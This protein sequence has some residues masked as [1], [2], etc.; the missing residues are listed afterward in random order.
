MRLFRSASKGGLGLAL[1]LGMLAVATQHSE[2]TPIPSLRDHRESRMAPLQILPVQFLPDA[3]RTASFAPSQ[4]LMAAVLEDAVHVYCKLRVLHGRAGRKMRR[5][6]EAWFSSR[7]AEW[8]FSFR[9]ICDILDLDAEK[10]LA[11][12][13]LWAEPRQ[14]S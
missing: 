2:P 14:L 11:R 5:E 12:L 9:N 7:D 4:Q 6:L 3:R 10:I 1:Q 13:G 8:L